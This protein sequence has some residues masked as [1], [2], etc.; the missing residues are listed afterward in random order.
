[1][2][3]LV[4]GLCLNAEIKFW[5]SCSKE[6]LSYKCGEPMV[7]TVYAHNTESDTVDA[8]L[9]VSSED[10]R[11]LQKKRIVM[12]NDKPLY[13]YTSCNEPGFARV[14]V[15]ALDKNGKSIRDKWGR[16]VSFNGGAGAGVEMLRPTK[17]E[18][19]D[20]DAF[21]AKQVR[22]MKAVPMRAVETKD[23]SD[24]EFI[25][26]ALQIDTVGAPASA[27]I[28]IPKNAKAK[29]LP[30]RAEFI[31]Y[32][33]DRIMFKKNKD[34][35]TLIV[36]RHSFELGRES[37]YYKK[38][39]QTTLKSFGLPSEKNFDREE[40]YFKYM[41]LRDLK[42]L[43]YAKTLP[44]WNGKD[45]TVYGGSMGGFQSIFVAALD[46][47]VT[48]CKP[49]IP[50]LSDIWG[51]VGTHR[52]KSEFAP[53]WTYSMRYYDCAFAIKRIKCP[54]E[55]DAWLGDYICPPSGIVAMFNNAPKGTRLTLGQNGVHEGRDPATA[56]VHSVLVKE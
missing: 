28:A 38:L 13:V 11:A 51:Y 1:M 41:I 16:P 12:Q 20:F 53:D 37:E 29:S 44:Q 42:A 27:W 34:M 47:D 15:R 48:L 31:G 10:G 7:F 52:A 26:K 35:I 2:F 18:P 5:G 46:P 9:N 6:P 25:V 23:F 33:C 45:I 54:I 36:E 56:E 40:V 14:F 21:W 39:S 30:I 24:A 49:Y 22:A 17:K 43:D 4:F 19:K 55:I 50:W 8:E 32:G 3:S